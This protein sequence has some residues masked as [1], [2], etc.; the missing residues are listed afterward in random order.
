MAVSDNKLQNLEHSKGE[1]VMTQK[2]KSWSEIDLQNVEC[3]SNILLWGLVSY[4]FS[5]CK[6]EE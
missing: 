1:T 4:L 5:L 6:Q 2:N 3:G